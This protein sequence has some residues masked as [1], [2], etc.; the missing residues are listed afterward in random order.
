MTP[1]LLK[2]FWDDSWD[3]NT[4]LSTVREK[5]ANFVREHERQALQLQIDS[6]HALYLQACGQRDILMDQ[7][8][9]QIAAIRGKLQ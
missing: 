5:F 8:R 7:Q 6:L 3:E 2:Q 1:Q 9:S 4:P